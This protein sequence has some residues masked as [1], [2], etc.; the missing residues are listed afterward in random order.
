[1]LED[2]DLNAIHDEIVRK[3]VR[4]LLNLVEKLSVDLRA[5]REENQ[6]LRD[7]SIVFGSAS[8]LTIHFMGF[9]SAEII[10]TS[11]Q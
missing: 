4:Q 11:I 2:L 3:Q 6:T 7:E 10:A 1:M 5:L 9:L 8:I